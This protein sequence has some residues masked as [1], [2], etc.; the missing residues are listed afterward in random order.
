MMTQTARFTVGA[1]PHWRTRTSIR[2]VNLAYI[3]ALLP[4]AFMG[5][6][7]HAFGLR[8]ATLAATI[9]AVSPVL[10]VGA[11]EMGVGAGPLWFFG[12]LGTLAL[13]MGVGLLA[14]Y[15]SQVVMRQPYQAIN[16]HG[17]LMGLLLA[18]FSPPGIPAWVLAIGVFVAIFLGKQIF[19]GIGSYPM[20]PAMIGWLV[21]LLS[22]QHFVYP[23]GAASIATPAHL[24]V[25]LTAF[26]GVV[27]CLLGYVRWQIP[28]GVLFGVVLFSLLF[29]GSLEGGVVKQLLTGHVMLGAFFVATDGTCSPANRLPALL[30]GIFIGLIIVLI[31]AFGIWP[32]A[33]P[34]AVLLGNVLNPLLDRIQP[35]VR[36][37]EVG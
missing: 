31:R 26:G 14:E 18:L 2:R 6:V 27:L 15:L 36:L 37:M 8:D 35:R 21:L 10:E 34:F 17:V 12:I 23:V 4:A 13:G 9:G 33:I 30:Y 11:R 3:F 1:A 16:G 28:L 22:W 20:H 5:A 25:L 29:S 19:G 24:T 32:D 7:I